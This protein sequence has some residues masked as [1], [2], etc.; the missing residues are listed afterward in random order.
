MP[1]AISPLVGFDGSSAS[2]IQIGLQAVLY[3]NARQEV[4]LGN[5]VSKASQKA[6]SRRAMHSLKK[7]MS[8]KEIGQRLPEV[9]CGSRHLLYPPGTFE[10]AVLL[11]MEKS[12]PGM[13]P[14]DCPGANPK[15]LSR[16]QRA[17]AQLSES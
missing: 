9:S 1:L 17:L 15:R 13:N 12:A 11:K 10:M 3:I 14:L 5:R 6:L 4:D 7:A 8:S 2:T 16:N